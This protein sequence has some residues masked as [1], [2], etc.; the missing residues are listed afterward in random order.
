MLKNIKQLNNSKYF[1]GSLRLYSVQTAPK[2]TNFQD[3]WNK[4]KSYNEIPKLS[5]FGLIRGFLPGGH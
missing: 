4:A 5:K 2:L 3:E 1:Q